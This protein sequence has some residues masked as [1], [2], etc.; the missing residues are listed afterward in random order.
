MREYSKL[1]TVAA[2]LPY[3]SMIVLGSA[4][5]AF[6]FDYSLA[7]FISAFIYF[8]YG[9]VGAL[10]IMIFVCPY[11]GYYATLSCPCGYG[12]ISAKIVRKQDRLCFSEK[13]KRHIP[14]I[15][16]LWLIPMICGIVSIYI[17]F[18]WSKIFLLAAFVLESCVLLPLFSKKHGCIDCPQKDTC[19]WMVKPATKELPGDALWPASQPGSQPEA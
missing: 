17:T 8:V 13:F 2:N 5:I 7:A 1:Q 19:P 18:S 15:V 16:P 14:V 9:I 6:V 10:W 4:L 12:K 11:C 3:A